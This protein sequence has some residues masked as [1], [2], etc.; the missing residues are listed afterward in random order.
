MRLISRTP[1]ACIAWAL[2]S[3]TLTG[4]ESCARGPGSPGMAP[5]EQSGPLASSAEPNPKLPDPCRGFP[6]PEDQHFVAKGLCARLVAQKQGE[7]RQLTFAPNGD[8][9]G[10]TVQ[11]AIRRYRDIDGDGAFAGPAEIVEWANVGGKNGNN[12]HIDGGFLYAGSPDGVKRW[13]YAPDKDQGGP[14]QDVVVGQ[15]GGGNHP[16]HPV[17]VYDGWLYDDSGSA[18]NTMRPMPADYDT[19]RSVLKRFDLSKLVP[20]KPFQWNEGEPFVVGVRNVTGFTKDAAGR[21]IGVVSGIDDLR[22]G[23]EDV[24][25]DNPGEDVVLLEKGQAHGYPFCFTASR[26]VVGGQVVPPG[27]RLHADAASQNP[28]VSVTRSSKDD[29]WCKAHTTPPLT[30]LQAH[31]SPLGIAF[32]DRDDGV[33]PSRWKGGAFV[34]LHGSWDR[35]PSTGH[36]VVWLPFDASGRTVMPVSTAEATTFP[37]EVVFGGGNV[38]GPRDGAWGWRAG[39]RGE[40]QVR[41]V[42]VAISPLDGA[43]YVSS[44]N[45]TVPLKGPSS[46]ADGAIYRIGRQRN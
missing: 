28:L 8:L 1:S 43:L 15:P 18:E 3:V 32:L 19:N 12:C 34:A 44:D 21:M 2:A 14:G 7:L 37:Y 6:L 9:F 13:A 27:T 38:N 30:F 23:A 36:K 20:G 22:Y 33:L 31:S 26:V 11:G 45:G 24:H 4:C 40:A 16:Y 5:R 41:P 25:A 17:H 10:V 29:A 39:D 42:G 35:N 46:T